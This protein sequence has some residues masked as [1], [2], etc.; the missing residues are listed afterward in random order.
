MIMIRLFATFPPWILHSERK[1]EKKKSLRESLSRMVLEA[2]N[3][4]QACDNVVKGRMHSKV[5]HMALPFQFFNSLVLRND[6]R[7]T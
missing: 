6:L 1:R 4:Y 3:L 7:A 2:V 5:R